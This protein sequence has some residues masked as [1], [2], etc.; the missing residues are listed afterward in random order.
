MFIMMKQSTKRALILIMVLIITG[1]LIWGLGYK[2]NLPAVKGDNLLTYLPHKSPGGSLVGVVGVRG[3][4]DKYFDIKKTRFYKSFLE[5]KLY[6]VLKKN[7]SFESALKNKQL[8]INFTGDIESRQVMEIIG[9]SFIVAFYGARPNPEYVIISK[10]KDKSQIKSILNDVLKNS[11][12]TVDSYKD[13]GIDSYSRDGYYTLYNSHLVAGNSMGLIKNT[14][15]LISGS[16]NVTN[17]NSLYPELEKGMDVGAD[18][19]IFTVNK[20]LKKII[21]NYSNN[22]EA[23]SA[24]RKTEGVY[25]YQEI[26][27]KDGI[28]IKSRG[29][30]SVKKEETK[31][32]DL[33]NVRSLTLN[34]VPQSPLLAGAVNNTTVLKNYDKIGSRNIVG[35]NIYH[36]IDK[37]IISNIDGEAG[38][39]ILGPE[40]GKM[41]SILPGL[42]I[43][44][45]VKSSDVAQKVSA[46]VEDILGVEM[47][48]KKYK[49]N[50]Y[51]SA[52]L[53][54][55]FSQDIKISRA[56]IE[57]G[58]KIYVVIASPSRVIEKIIDISR[59]RQA[60]LKKSSAWRGVSEFLPKKYSRYS[61][62]D[63]NAISNTVGLFLAKLRGNKDMENFLNTAPFSFIGPSASAGSIDDGGTVVYTYIPVQDLN[64]ENWNKIFNS[65]IPFV[66]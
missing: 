57:Y 46:N 64:R 30:G 20:E 34:L 40:E 8:D 54:L 35:Q 2:F 28:Y 32:G 17:F 51:R 36:R 22:T 49:Q 55:L 25:T 9:K 15:E 6:K 43:Y 42:A 19:Y 65:L 38:Y 48:S 24:L 14:M 66:D 59:G 33:K 29:S 18:G 12:L 50:S 39:A 45:E 1:I 47:K 16:E 63:P 62:V 4:S 10:V 7:A 26:Y 31:S 44:L 11:D 53:P 60:S 37:D 52:S 21:D 61:Y 13:R 41:S 23:L 56:T 3:L 58:G 27:F 5:S